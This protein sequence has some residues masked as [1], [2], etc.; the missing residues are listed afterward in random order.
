MGD[1]REAILD[2]TTH[3][4]KGMSRKQERK[5]RILGFGEEKYG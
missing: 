4:N 3:L 2:K 5:Q 1:D